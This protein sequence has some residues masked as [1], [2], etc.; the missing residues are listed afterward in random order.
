MLLIIVLSFQFVIGN[1]AKKGEA[2]LLTLTGNTIIQNNTRCPASIDSVTKIGTCTTAAVELNSSTELTLDGGGS[3][4]KY[5]YIMRGASTFKSLTIQNYAVVTHEPLLVADIN[6]DRVTVNS[7]GAIKK[8][9]ITVDGDLT[10]ANYGSINVDGKG[11][12]GGVLSGVCDIHK[13]GGSGSGWIVGDAKQQGY[14]LGGGAGVLEEDSRRTTVG[15]GGALGGLGGAPSTSGDEYIPNANAAAKNSSSS[16]QYGSGGGAVMSSSDKD[17][18]VY[19]N[20]SDPHSNGS[21]GGGAIQL[22]VRNVIKIPVNT[23]ISANGSNGINVGE[24]AYKGSGSGGWIK[25]VAF[26]AESSG[27]P[28]SV[29]AG[30]GNNSITGLGELVMPMPSPPLFNISAKGGDSAYVQYGG[31]SGGRIEFSFAKMSSS[32]QK[33]LTPIDRGNTVGCDHTTRLGC[34]SAFSPYALRK[35]DFIKVTIAISN[36]GTSNLGL[37]DDWLQTR[38]QIPNYK[39]VPQVNTISPSTP[40]V[41]PLTWTSLPSGTTEVSYECKVQ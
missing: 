19:V 5:Q 18:G 30:I 24:D 28:I 6:A 37:T 13:Y 41:D 8:V 7:S 27:S 4:N 10:L 33:T 15:G 17:N 39:C 21:A 38:Y 31:G 9:D 12:P 2:A 36:E 26:N 32:V 23:S 3:A 22:Y 40:I 20:C 11:Y 35:D 25:I 1:R 34:N 16:L 14:G 29:A